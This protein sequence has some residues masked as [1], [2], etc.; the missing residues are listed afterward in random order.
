MVL[1]VFNADSPLTRLL[2]EVSIDTTMAPSFFP[3]ISKEFLVLVLGSKKRREIISLER[4][5]FLS[6][7]FLILNA[8]SIIS[9]IS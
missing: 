7:S 4:G 6:P 9:L 3:A 5:S 1:T 8:V 2:P